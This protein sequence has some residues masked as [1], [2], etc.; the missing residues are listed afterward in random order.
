MKKIR[1]Q[2]LRSYH[3]NPISI[4]P[5]F[6]LILFLL[7]NNP[8]RQYKNR[9]YLRNNFKSLKKVEI[10]TILWTQSMVKRITEKKTKRSQTMQL[11]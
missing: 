10:L 7:S 9:L 1:T 11:L 4:N 6:L 3:H 8:R 5:R 2:E